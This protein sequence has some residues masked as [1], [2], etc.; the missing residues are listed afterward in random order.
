V[1]EEPST[2]SPG[3]AASSDDINPASQAPQTETAQAEEPPPPKPRPR[4]LARLPRASLRIR[5]IA[6]V[7][8]AA[9]IAA[10]VFAVMPSSPPPKPAYTSLPAPCGTVSLE[11]LAKYLPSP[12]GTPVSVASPG[13]V[14]TDSCKWSTVARGEDR[15]LWLDLSV[16]GA[17]SAIN[18]AQQ[19]Y[20]STLS[21][22]ECHCKGVTVSTRRVTGLGDQ[23]TAMLATA[24]L[25]AGISSPHT[26]ADLIVQSSNSEMV[27][28]YSATAAETPQPSDAAELTWLISVAH[29]ILVDLARPAAVVA[30]PVVPEPHYAGSRNPCRL[31][32]ATTMARYAPD[33]TASPVTATGN[34]LNPPGTQT[35]ACAWA[36][37]NGPILLNLTVYRDAL[38]AGE[39]FG[40]DA[41]AFGQSDPVTTVTGTR[42]LDDLGEQA[43][44]IFQTSSS[45]G[46][47]LDML[48]WS[49]NIELDYSINL[50]NV[51]M[52]A[53]TMLAAGTA[54]ARDGLAILAGPTA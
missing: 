4:W 2:D 43:V 26:G 14:K 1:S 48:V 53:S 33:A 22:V 45:L 8:A 52:S 47:G 37:G 18:N 46:S 21:S 7:A 23:A 15:T 5:V 42:W 24:G 9:V 36:S 12:T 31:I 30:A 3:I 32:S 25:D 40:N 28:R 51:S 49:G 20:D 34:P 38:S 16:F 29:D 35:S 13:T 17:P 19:S 10:I 6:V 54:M 27:L 41:L 39:G 11:A 50:A 44:A